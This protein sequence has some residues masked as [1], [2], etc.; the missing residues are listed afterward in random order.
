MVSRSQIYANC[1]TR[2]AHLNVETEEDVNWNGICWKTWSAEKLR[3]RWADLKA[4]AKVD[5]S[6]SHRGEYFFQYACTTSLMVS[7]R[8]RPTVEGSLGE[9]VFININHMYSPHVQI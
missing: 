9:H 1:S 8:Y 6:M 4:D 7:S 3:K 2:V 5:A